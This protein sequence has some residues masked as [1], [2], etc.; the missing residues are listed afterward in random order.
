MQTFPKLPLVEAYVLASGAS[1]VLHTGSI[2]S[3]VYS[4]K[5][6]QKILSFKFKKEIVPGSVGVTPVMGSFSK[7]SFVPSISPLPKSTK[8]VLPLML[9]QRA[10]RAI[11]G[12]GSF[13]GSDTATL[14]PT[15]PR[16]WRG[17]V[18]MRAPGFTGVCWIEGCPSISGIAEVVDDV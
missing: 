11:S 16:G 18:H 8:I 10:R 4:E 2:D 13:A 15:K 6:V 3:Y 7:L 9:L 1:E 17:S 14:R 5:L 12:A